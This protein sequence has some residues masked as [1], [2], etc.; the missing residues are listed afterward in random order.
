MEDGE[1]SQEVAVELTLDAGRMDDSMK[2][3]SPE[4]QAELKK[5]NALSYEEQ[6]EIAKFAIS[7]PSYI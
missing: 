4:A 2:H 3:E 6:N 1:I 5:F 7:A